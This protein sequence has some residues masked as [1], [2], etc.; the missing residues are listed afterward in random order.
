MAY[1][2][3]HRFHIAEHTLIPLHRSYLFRN[4]GPLD[5]DYL[6]DELLQDFTTLM[7]GTKEVEKDPIQYALIAASIEA[8]PPSQMTPQRKKELFKEALYYR[9]IEDMVGFLFDLHMIWHLI[10]LGTNVWLLSLA[11]VGPRL[12]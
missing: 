1:A 5:D 11:E 12:N 4:I 10:V 2:M 9:Y 7:M 3:I 6:D 8:E